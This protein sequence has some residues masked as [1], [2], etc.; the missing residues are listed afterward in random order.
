M[1]LYLNHI[2]FWNW[3]EILKILFFFTYWINTYDL[4]N[5]VYGPVCPTWL[6]IKPSLHYSRIFFSKISKFCCFSFKCQNYILG[7]CMILLLLQSAKTILVHQKLK[8]FLVHYLMVKKKANTYM[9]K[10]KSS[11][12]KKNKSDSFRAVE[13]KVGSS[14]INN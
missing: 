5:L 14:R 11:E 4:I 2:C 6:Y 1:L 9:A 10:M 3:R 13:V 8:K 12:E 7:I